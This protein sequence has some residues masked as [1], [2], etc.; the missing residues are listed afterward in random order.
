M[1]AGKVCGKWRDKVGMP[2]QE[3]QKVFFLESKG[4]WFSFWLDFKLF[5]SF[6]FQFFKASQL[7]IPSYWKLVGETQVQVVQVEMQQMQEMSTEGN[8]THYG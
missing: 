6:S 4:D 2:V 5:G 8:E 1:A 3:K 7:D